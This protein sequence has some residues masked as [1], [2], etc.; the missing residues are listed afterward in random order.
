V[1][2]PGGQG[3]DDGFVSFEDEVI[4]GSHDD[5]HEGGAGRDGDG[6]GEEDVVHTIGSGPADGDI[7][8]ERLAGTAAAADAERADVAAGLGGGGV[9]G[10]DGDAGRH[11]D[12]D[13]GGAAEGAAH[14][15]G[16]EDGVIAGVA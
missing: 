2:G 7:D 15:V 5:G 3:E 9:G 8:G 14:G 1:I 16:D 12:G 4:D 10:S 6:A 13:V 11:R